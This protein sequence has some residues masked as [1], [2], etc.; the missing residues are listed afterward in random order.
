MSTTRRR[1][2]G[3]LLALPF[4]RHLVPTKAEGVETDNPCNSSFVPADHPADCLKYDHEP[5]LV[6][7]NP[8]RYLTQAPH[9]D[10][11]DA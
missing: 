5:E 4:V 11:W 1:F 6:F 3:A 7:E 10:R 2:L 8:P 9:V